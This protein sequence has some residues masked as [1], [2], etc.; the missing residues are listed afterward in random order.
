[1]EY[2]N[3]NRDEKN[4]RDVNINFFIVQKYILCCF[5]Y[6]KLT[7]YYCEVLLISVKPIVNNKDIDE[8]CFDVCCWD[9]LNS[10]INFRWI[11]RILICV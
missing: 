10:F 11:F 2:V 5:F 4:G 7:L 9:D 8:Y 6:L 3:L 1:M